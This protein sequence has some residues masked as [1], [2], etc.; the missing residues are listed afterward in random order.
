MS[1][2][3]IGQKLC[4]LN[5]FYGF[6]EF[7]FGCLGG[8]KEGFRWERWLGLGIYFKLIILSPHL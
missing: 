6:W 4:P 8:K 1:H 3:S 2:N 5:I 7:F